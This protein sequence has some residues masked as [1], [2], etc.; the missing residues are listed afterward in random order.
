MTLLSSFYIRYHF[1]PIAV[2]RKRLHKAVVTYMDPSSNNQ[3]T[4]DT[5]N[6]SLARKLELGL[7]KNS[8]YVQ[9]ADGID[10]IIYVF[11]VRKAGFTGTC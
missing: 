6:V 8:T 1:S 9:G 3:T 2:P 5:D 10:S 11:E 7:F 4:A